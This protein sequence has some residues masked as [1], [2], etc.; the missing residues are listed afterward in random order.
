MQSE[1]S[2][3]PEPPSVASLSVNRTRN[4]QAVNAFLE[5][6]HPLGDVPGWKAAWTATYKGYIVA[7]LVLSRPV[8]PDLDDG[9]RLGITRLGLHN[10]RPANTG[11]W[12][13]G[14][15]R[16]WVRLEGYDELLAYAGVK[17]NYGTVYE[18]A[19]FKLVKEETGVRRDD[20]REGRETHGVYDRRKWVYRFN[21]S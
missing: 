12:L 20:T 7:C 1:V 16:P 15:I 8:S 3:L 2:S 11:S 19:G 13:I 21:E 18:A 6:H 5:A 14:Q 4:K 17:H 9:S 10:S